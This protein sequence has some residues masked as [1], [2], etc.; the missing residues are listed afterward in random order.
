MR[1]LRIY[2][3]FL[4]FSF[5]KA[6]EF[7]VDFTFRIIMDAIFYIVNIG[8]YKILYSHTSTLAGWREDQIMVFICS[9][10]M[11]D[12]LYMTFFSSNM[13]W[14]PTFINRGDLDFYLIRPV[15]SLF[16]LSLREFSANSLFNLIISF[17]LMF[18][19]L[20]H[21]QDPIHPLALI[22]YFLLLINGSGLHYIIQMFMILPVFWTQSPRG[23]NDLFFSLGVA[24]ERP[25]R[26]YKGWLRIL[27]CFVMPFALIVSFPA[28]L[29]F[30]SF[31]SFIFLHL[32]VI[33]ICF[34]SLL[35]YLWKIALKNY[36][37]A[38][39]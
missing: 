6:L 5:S 12:A 20:I 25:D 39:S 3:Y 28:R 18:W 2:F 16:F 1:Y 34:W 15:S 26:I 36:S 13:W 30:E 23:F 35:L 27:F 19:A 31:N 22:G 14:L 17:G 7:R 24:M 37:S 33:S 4:R 29:F 9:Y 21:Y 10:L 32:L 38:S 11:I 8:F